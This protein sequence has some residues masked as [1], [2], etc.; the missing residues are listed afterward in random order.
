MRP[1]AGRHYSG[2]EWS[3]FGLALIGFAVLAV[4]GFVPLI[5]GVRVGS[6]WLLVHAAGAPLFCTGMLLLVLTRAESCRPAA[7]PT[8]AD[9]RF[10]GWHKL[11]FWLATALT[12]ALVLTALLTMTPWLGTDDQQGLI[13]THRRCAWALVALAILQIVRSVLERRSKSAR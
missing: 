6:W 1:L 3:A 4:T 11:S 13:A 12:V 9:P 8:A 7:R 2:W 10:S 5:R